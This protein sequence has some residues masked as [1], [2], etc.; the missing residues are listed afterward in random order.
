MKIAIIWDTASWKST[1]WDKLS[2]KLN[3]KVYHTDMIRIDKKWVEQSNDTVKQLIKEVL[4]KKDWIIEWNALRAD[5]IER[6]KEADIV[7]LFD[8]SKINTLK[9]V[10]KRRRKINYKNEKRAWFHSNQFNKLRLWYYIP[11][12]FKNFPKRKIRL[13]KL[14]KKLNKKTIVFKSYRDINLILK[15]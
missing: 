3:I 2:K 6:F 11:Y 1:F 5:H 9:N 15:K 12:I 14:L 10:I 13:K 4:K 7:Y 8:F